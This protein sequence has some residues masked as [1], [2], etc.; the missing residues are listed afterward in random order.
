MSSKHIHIYLKP[1]AKDASVESVQREIAQQERLVEAAKK[2]GKEPTGTVVQRLKFLKEELAKA[3]NPR[4]DDALSDDQFSS[5]V[6]EINSLLTD[7]SRKAEALTSQAGGK[8]DPED[9][10]RGRKMVGNAHKLEELIDKARSFA[11]Q[12]R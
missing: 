4:T 3:K 8:M 10:E 5:K 9:L 1:K 6:R 11:F 2:A 12:I 7:A